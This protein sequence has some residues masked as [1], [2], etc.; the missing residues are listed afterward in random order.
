[1]RWWTLGFILKSGDISYDFRLRENNSSARSL[2]F[3]PPLFSLF[4]PKSEMNCC[5][6]NIILSFYHFVLSICGA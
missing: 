4:S 2:L 5:S 3:S 6:P 1:M